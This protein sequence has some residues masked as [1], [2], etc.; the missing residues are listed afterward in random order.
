MS[1]FLLAEFKSA[2]AA[3]DAARTADEG[4]Q[5]P[6]DALTPHPVDGVADHLVPPRTVPSIGY[7]QVIAGAIGA[8]IGYA[9]QWYSA[10][11]DYPIIS[12]NRP[13]YSWQVFVIVPY[14]M[15]ILFAAVFGVLSWMI[16]SG[17]PRPHHPL[18]EAAITERAVQDRYLL[19]FA[20]GE[21]RAAWITATL[22]PHAVHEVQI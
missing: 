10:T 4:G 3:A 8:A 7:V 17:L 15:T 11:I 22:K 19:V 14:E 20:P 12:G 9:M 2:H 1:A 6:M 5:P 13:L 21:H 16:M 18:F